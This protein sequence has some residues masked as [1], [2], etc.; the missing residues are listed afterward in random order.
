MDKEEKMTLRE[1]ISYM[2]KYTLGKV[3][4]EEYIEAIKN[5]ESDNN[6]SAPDYVYGRLKDYTKQNKDTMN[7]VASRAKIL[8]VSIIILIAVFVV[9]AIK[10]FV[11]TYNKVGLDSDNDGL[12]NDFEVEHGTDPNEYTWNEELN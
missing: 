11:K 3:S 1:L 7:K 9:F 12:S 8:V 6:C 5:Y 4:K 10:G 2:D